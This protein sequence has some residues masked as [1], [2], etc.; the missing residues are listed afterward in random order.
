MSDNLLDKATTAT[1]LGEEAS[2]TP[3]STRRRK[4]TRSQCEPPAVIE[5]AGK[6]QCREDESSCLRSPTPASSQDETPAAKPRNLIAA[7]VEIALGERNRGFRFSTQ[8]YAEHHPWLALTN[9]YGTRF[10]SVALVLSRAAQLDDSVWPIIE[11][12]DLEA[13]LLDAGISTSDRIVLSAEDCLAN[14][15]E[16]GQ[17]R[18]RVLQDCAKRIVFP[19]LGLKSYSSEGESQ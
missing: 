4:R 3:E 10:P 12:G 1:S 9:P 5:Q 19:L 14:V 13:A 6:R 18:A 16:M 2:A 11:L 17:A 8:T 15:G 7:L